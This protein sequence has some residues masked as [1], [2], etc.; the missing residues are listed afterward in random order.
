MKKNSNSYTGQKLEPGYSVTLRVPLVRHLDLRPQ[1][2]A[3]LGV[4]Y[5]P[6]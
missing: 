5:L 4:A 3:H 2:V 6:L 1:L